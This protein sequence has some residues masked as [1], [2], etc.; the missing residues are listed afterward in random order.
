MFHVKQSR[1]SNVQ[2]EPYDPRMLRNKHPGFKIRVLTVKKPWGFAFTDCGRLLDN[3]NGHLNMKAGTP[4]V[5]HGGVGVDPAG[6]QSG[7]FPLVAPPIPKPSHLPK[8][9]LGVAIFES[10]VQRLAYG[11]PR[12]RWEIE[13]YSHRWLF[14]DFH[15]FERPVTSVVG[16]QG[17]P[18]LKSEDQESVL[19]AWYRLLS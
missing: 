12:K 2:I 4:I 8:G 14:S 15:R 17:L 1:Y 10:S 5:I 7:A 3:R 19:E 16:R 18:W 9:A 13:R 6:Y 11:D